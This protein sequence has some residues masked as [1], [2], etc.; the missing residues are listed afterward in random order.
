MGTQKIIEPALTAEEIIAGFEIMDKSITKALET[1]K[2]EDL[3]DFHF[4]GEE[5][6]RRMPTFKGCCHL[7]DHLVYLKDQFHY[8]PQYDFR[9]HT[10]AYT[11]A[12]IGYK[13]IN[14]NF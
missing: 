14:D 8:L 10:A 12:V 7:P 11:Y 2:S 3:H 1:G 13:R 9:T 6:M 5:L 4:K